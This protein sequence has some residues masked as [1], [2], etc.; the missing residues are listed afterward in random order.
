M[1]FSNHICIIIAF[2]LHMLNIFLFFTGEELLHTSDLSKRWLKEMC[3]DEDTGN[4]SQGN[5]S[6][7]GQ[8][9]VIRRIHPLGPKPMDKT[10]KYKKALKLC[11]EISSVLS[12]TGGRQFEERMDVLETILKH[13]SSKKEVIILPV[14]SE[15]G[16]ECG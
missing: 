16:V 8:V 1:K 9:K 10:T 15:G 5:T 12:L 11:S 6:K 13:W 7:S 3:R 4:T 14:N 2:G